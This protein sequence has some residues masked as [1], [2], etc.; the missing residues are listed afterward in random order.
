MKKN[1]SLTFFLLL[2]FLFLPFAQVSIHFFRI[3][4][5]LPELSLL[6]AASSFL[7]YERKQSIRIRYPK[8]IYLVGSG[9]ILT[10]SILALFQGGVTSQELGAF[11]S[12]IFFPMMFAALL[13]QVGE[14][15][16]ERYGMLGAWFLG[17]AFTALVAL[18]PFFSFLIT[19]DGRLRFFYPSPNHLAMFIVPGILIGTFFF[20]RMI[21]LEEKN[22]KKKKNLAQGLLLACVLGLMSAALVQ[23]AS[24]GGLISLV[25]GMIILI[26]FTSSRM[27][28][29]LAIFFLSLGVLCL[30]V[31]TL[32]IDWGVLAS[33]QAQSSL[34]SRAMI[35]NTS[36]FLIEAHP[37][38]GVGM[39]NFQDAYLAAQP[40]FPFYR[41]WA[42]PHPHNLFLAFWLFTGLTGLTGFL[43]LCFGSS[44]DILKRALNSAT[45]YE[46]KS[47]DALLLSLFAAFLVFGLVDTPY[48]KNDLAFSFWAMVA[49]S[50]L[51]E[52]TKRSGKVRG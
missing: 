27:T 30:G 31:F 7:V 48:F 23:T 32:T 26:L 4:V 50:L 39:R 15:P 14:D 43:I 24:M 6:L 51:P 16:R 20:V 29:K 46:G 38:I 2:T 13:F 44:R 52:E 45:A 19:Y 1:P 8:K 36:I 12:W 40:H 33:G 35:W 37:V 41:E 47:M 3:P 21:F 9:L 34:G 17:T 10:G 22:D 28:G 5:Y 42:V 25:A 18:L 11:K 49:L